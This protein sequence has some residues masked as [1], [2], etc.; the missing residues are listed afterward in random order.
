ML[1]L[2]AVLLYYLL[3]PHTLPTVISIDNIVECIKQIIPKFVAHCP[4]QS[5]N[6]KLATMKMIALFCWSDSA[7]TIANYLYLFTLILKNCPKTLLLT[8]G[9]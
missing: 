1:L 8:L 2:P 3:R 7:G 5:Y 6:L 9:G 4:L